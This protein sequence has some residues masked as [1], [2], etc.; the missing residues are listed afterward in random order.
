MSVLVNSKTKLLVQGITGGEGTFHT[1]Q[2]IA[3]EIGRAHV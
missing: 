1:E 3:Y 2:A